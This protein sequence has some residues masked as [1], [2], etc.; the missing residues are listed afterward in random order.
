MKSTHDLSSN[1]ESRIKDMFV[2]FF[3]D[4]NCCVEFEILFKLIE[5]NLSVNFCVF[6][7][8]VSMF[9][10]T[11]TSFSSRFRM[12]RILLNV[13]RACRIL[14]QIILFYTHTNY[15]FSIDFKL[16]IEPDFR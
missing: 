2:T 9:F 16:Q 14:M 6:Y 4:V 1:Y 10:G 7:Q 11:L 12:F 5:I 13:K 8:C 3:K 15:K